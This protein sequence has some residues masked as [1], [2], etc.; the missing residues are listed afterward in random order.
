MIIDVILVSYNQ[1]PF[2]QQAIESI[3]DQ[4]IDAKVRVIIADDCS[5]DGTK[6]IIRT[7]AK[8]SPF[9]VVFLPEEKNLGISKNYQRAFK[10][11]SGDYIAVLEGDDYW[12]TPNHLQQHLDFLEANPNC[13]LSMN[14]I[15]YFDENSGIKNLSHWWYPSSP[16][17]VDCKEQIECGNQL[18]NL[19]ACVLRASCV[20]KLPDSLFNLS[21]ADWMLGVMLSQQGPLGL[22]EESTSIYRMNSSSSWASR[23]HLRQTLSMFNLSF[24]YDRFQRLE[25]HNSWTLFRRRL[26]KKEL[27]L[28]KRKMIKFGKRIISR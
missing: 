18:G 20:R 11:C 27:L 26:I 22:L 8:K 19:S 21:I 6:E 9:E 2:I 4:K 1:S 12:T 28:M 25:H 7:L 10:A 5:N 24:K 17:Y 13:S 15:T 14:A 3:F 23:G 16:Y